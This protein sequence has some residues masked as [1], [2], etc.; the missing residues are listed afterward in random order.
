MGKWIKVCTLKNIYLAAGVCALVA[1]KQ[2][3]V[4][5]PSE[6]EQ[7]FAI[8]NMDPFARSSVLSRGL[9]GQH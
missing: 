3:A 9:I 7:V 1:G 5:H 2:V 4:F 8:N 6:K